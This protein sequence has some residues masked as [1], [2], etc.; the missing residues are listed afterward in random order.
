MNEATALFDLNATQLLI[1]GL[2]GAVGFIW[3]RLENR[4]DKIQDSMDKLSTELHAR[5]SGVKDDLKS[6]EDHCSAREVER[7]GESGEMKAEVRGLREA[8]GMLRFQADSER[9]ARIDR[10]EKKA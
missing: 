1:M 7:A 6:H 4:L 3:R 2:L 10:L 5:I 9:D 8:V